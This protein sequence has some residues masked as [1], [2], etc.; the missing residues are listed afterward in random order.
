MNSIIIPHRA[1]V[2]IWLLVTALGASLAR[3]VI[4]WLAQRRLNE[5]KR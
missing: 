5:T 1:K 3:L 4:L 2:L